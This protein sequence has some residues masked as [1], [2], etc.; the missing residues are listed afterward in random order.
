MDA[1]S[2]LQ[3]V[4]AGDIDLV[5]ACADLFASPEVQ[6][7]DPATV[8][9]GS[10]GGDELLPAGSDAD[11]IFDPFA[12]A[13]DLDNTF[14]VV[15]WENAKADWTPPLTPSENDSPLPPFSLQPAPPPRFLDP[16]DVCQLG[17]KCQAFEIPNFHHV[18][19][20]QFRPSLYHFPC[21]VQRPKVQY[22]TV[23]LLHYDCHEYA[24]AGQ[25]H[26]NQLCCL[27]HQGTCLCR[28][29]CVSW[30]RVQACPIF[31]LAS[32]PRKN[33]KI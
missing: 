17:Q 13:C 29:S 21:S 1:P 28:F 22:Q 9:P 18:V 33:P 14:A 11:S 30:C 19:H 27:C 8:V 26:N 25:N 20:R 24:T 12:D 5:A 23:H 7:H 3:D 16:M 31:L 32:E 15:P 6:D 10:P 2:F 4:D